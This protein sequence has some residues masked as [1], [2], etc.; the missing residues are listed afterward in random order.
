MYVLNFST[1]AWYRIHYTIKIIP[2]PCLIFVD[3]PNFISILG[4][5][6]LH[7]ETSGA[8]LEDDL[9]ERY[10]A[11]LVVIDKK[12]ASIPLDGYDLCSTKLSHQSCWVVGPN[13]LIPGRIKNGSLAPCA[14]ILSDLKFGYIH[15]MS[16]SF[17]S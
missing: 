17:R 9:S 5:I 3:I 14:A 2:Q 16:P 1:C 8:F 10:F 4:H 7:V 15:C 6:P 12:R 11:V 13:T